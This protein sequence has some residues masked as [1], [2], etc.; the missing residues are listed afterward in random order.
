MFIEDMTNI[1]L[2]GE[3]SVRIEINKYIFYDSLV[4]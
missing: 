2:Y 4:M 3:E 1:I